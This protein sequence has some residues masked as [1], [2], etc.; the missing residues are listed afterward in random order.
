M[1]V[2]YA[3][4]PDALN[5]ALLAL[6][7]ITQARGGQLHC[8]VGCGGDR[9]ATKRPLM[10]AEAEAH[11]HHLCLTSDNPRSEDPAHILVQM[12]AG[13]KAPA[14]AQVEP[15]R[16]RAIAN[17]VAMAAP[18]DVVLIA[19]KGHETTQEV[20]GVKHPFSD[21]EHARRALWAR[22]AHEGAPA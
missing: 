18:A 12:L 7:P 11:A 9:D 19:G 13:L 8:V 4:T 15:D 6:A 16:A 2:D 17:R 1:L 3:H 14:Q 10:A 5:K 20:A 22:V 21:I